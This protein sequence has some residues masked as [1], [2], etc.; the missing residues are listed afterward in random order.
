MDGEDAEY[1]IR[2]KEEK[3]AKLNNAATNNDGETRCAWTRKRT[4]IEA[5]CEQ[6][7]R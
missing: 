5:R 3:N 4:A 7:E 6:Y 2:D 1:D